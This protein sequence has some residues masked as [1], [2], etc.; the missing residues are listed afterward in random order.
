MD[1]DLEYFL[2]TTPLILFDNSILDLIS[3]STIMGVGSGGRGRAPPPEFLYM[4]QI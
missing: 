4:V 2:V 1:E 3:V